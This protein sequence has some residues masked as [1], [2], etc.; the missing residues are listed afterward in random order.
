MLKCLYRD[1]SCPKRPLPFHVGSLSTYPYLLEYTIK[2]T[3]IPF[4]TRSQQT[5]SIKGH[6]VMLGFECMISVTIAQLRYCSA[7]SAIDSM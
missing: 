2:Y 1:V 5:F 7:E 4:E 3:T 6:R